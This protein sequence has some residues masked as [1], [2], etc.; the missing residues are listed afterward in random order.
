MGTMASQITSLTI[1]YSTVDHLMTSSWQSCLEFISYCYTIAK[2]SDNVS[3]CPVLCDDLFILNWSIS[4][5]VYHR[6]SDDYDGDVD[7]DD[8]DDDDDEKTTKI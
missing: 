6:H 8:Y 3:L 4:D 2:D 7:D 1:V 5:N